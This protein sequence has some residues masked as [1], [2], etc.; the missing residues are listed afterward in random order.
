M[1]ITFRVIAT[2]QVTQPSIFK[3]SLGENHT[4]ARGR[5]A[6]LT[7]HL[8][9]LIT[10]FSFQDI[11]YQLQ[12]LRFSRAIQQDSYDTDHS[13]HITV[14]YILYM[15]E[16]SRWT[17]YVFMDESTGRHRTK[18]SG[19]RCPT[20]PCLLLRHRNLCSIDSLT[21][22]PPSRCDHYNNFQSKCPP[23]RRLHH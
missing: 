1:W 4:W 6:L 19:T 20:C 22:P 12:I 17:S 21:L 13:F 16:S 14:C 5:R 15:L 7:N 3:R 23:F 8:K 11:I 10:S 18:M 2:F 9:L